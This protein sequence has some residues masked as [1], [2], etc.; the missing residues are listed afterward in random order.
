ESACRLAEAR[1]RNLGHAEAPLEDGRGAM[2]PV[3]E[4]PRDDDRQ[5]ARGELLPPP[6]DRLELAAGA[7]LVQRQVDTDAVQIAPP[8]R[9]RD[10]SVQEAAAFIAVIGDVLV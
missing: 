6:C 1:D 8:S 3:V 4:V 2:P 7:A 9:H 10:H 5:A